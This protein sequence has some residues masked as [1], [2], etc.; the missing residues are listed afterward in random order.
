MESWEAM[1]EALLAAGPEEERER[2]RRRRGGRAVRTSATRDRGT[3]RSL[4]R[5]DGRAR[6]PGAQ[7][8]RERWHLEGTD[9]EREL[10]KSSGPWPRHAS[11]ARWPE[12]REARRRAET[13]ASFN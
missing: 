4:E 6:Q 5:S 3:R 7:R 11:N 9:L 1:T 10:I 12:T 2:E 8:E 13:R